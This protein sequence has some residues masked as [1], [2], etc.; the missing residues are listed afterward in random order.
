[1]ALAHRK[2]P[3]HLQAESIAGQQLHGNRAGLQ[4]L[5]GAGT[6]PSVADRVRALCILHVGWCSCPL[7]LQRLQL[8]AFPL[9]LVC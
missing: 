3:L 5:C 8:C 6:P 7:P 9:V 2:S 4:P 1:M